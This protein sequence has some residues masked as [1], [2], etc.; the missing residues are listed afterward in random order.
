MP[1]RGEQKLDMNGVKLTLLPPGVLDD[2][3][4]KEKSYWLRAL[5]GDL[6]VTRIPL[7]FSKSG[8]FTSEKNRISF[9]LKPELAAG[10]IELCGG[11]DSLVFTVLVA[12][13]TVCLHKYTGIEDVIVGTTIHERNGDT[14]AL[15][16]ALALRNRV[17]DRL[18]VAELLEN[19]KRTTGE[20]Y[21][22]QKYPLDRV[23]EL[24]N[25]EYPDNR[26]PFFNTIIVLES[27]N[28]KEN[29]SHLKHDILLEFSSRNGSISGAIEY[30]LRL[31]KAETI[32]VFARHYA[33]ALQDLICNPEAPVSSIELLSE[34][35][36]HELVFSLNNT[37]MEYP[38]DKTIHR[39][40]E[41]QVER[42][43]NQEAVVFEDSVLT[44][45]ELNLKANRL[46]NQLRALGVEQGTPVGICMDHCPEMVVGILGVLKAGGT[47]APLDPAHPSGRLSFIANDARLAVLLTQSRFV[48]R[49]AGERMR[50]ISLDVDLE[51]FSE[52]DD[53]NLAAVGAADNVAYVIYT[54][55]STGE[56]KGVMVKHRS[57]V[58]YIWWANRIYLR[59]E[60]LDFALYSSLAFDLTVTSIYLPLITGNKIVIYKADGE[61]TPIVKALKEGKVGVLKLTPSHL[62]LIKDMDN[63]DCRIERLIV[64]G[65]ALEVDLARRIHQSFG[66]DV[67]I[68]NEYGPTEATVGCMIHKFNPDRDDRAFVPIGRPA[69]NTQIYV[70]DQFLK[71][72]A[73]NVPGELYIAGDGLAQGYLN[74][75]DLTY[76][77]FIE[78][79]FVA[80]GRMYRTGDVARW[81][82]EGVVEFMGRKDEQVK[83]HGYRVELNEVRSA[84]NRHSQI[85]DSV[86]RV[87]KDEHGNDF[88]VAYYVSRQEI[89]TSQLRAFLAE[90]LIRETIPN[91][92]VHLRKLPLT[93]NGKI[94]YRALPTLAGARQSLGQTFETPRN[95]VEQELAAIWA[96]VLG[97]GQVSVYD[98]FFELGGHSLLSTQVISRVRAAFGVDLSLGLLFET[99]TI[100][101]LAREVI[102]RQSRQ[103]G[104]PPDVIKRIERGKSEQLLKR[105]DQLADEEVDH[106]LDELL[107]GKGRVNE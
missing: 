74:R 96:K 47:Y 91:V 61:A 102:D 38:K 33:K 65:E 52:T 81:L 35:E 12:A 59:N 23:L 85:R 9:E 76:D 14:S 49:F 2:R 19:V 40:F 100:A 45:R 13:L 37:Q 73:E 84:L 97:L 69:P 63:R 27:I 36:K 94:N 21:A 54:S 78:N 4:A 107:A 53:G 98:N 87:L 66:G 34:S 86:V 67:E 62:S 64:G 16:N 68:Y 95:P 75:E 43:P 83:F 93:L 8:A 29:I 39:L 11:S 90:S 42:T 88:M 104:K 106:L 70:L 18:T 99:P 105:L 57:L 10:L 28:N 50:I 26:A 17:D 22:N 77:R 6:V 60:N 25:I 89:E 103:N 80:G 48:N 31:F 72:V 15:N 24:L 71:P 44:Y 32:K 55:G 56:P 51:A 101:G 5:S 46:A 20:A 1:A 3:L 58:N 30:N 7:D 41:E 82:P 79:P 92:F